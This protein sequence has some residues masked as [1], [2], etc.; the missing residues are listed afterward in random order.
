MAIASRTYADLAD[1]TADI[2]AGLADAEPA[3]KPTGSPARTLAKGA[4]RS[5]ICILLAFALVGVVTLTQSGPVV[6]IAL[7]SA[8]IAILAASAFLGYGVVNAWQE[9]RLHRQL[10]PTSRRDGRKLHGGRPDGTGHDPTLPRDR[11]NRARADLRF[12]RSR[13]GRPHS[14]GRGFRV[15]RAARPVPDLV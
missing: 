15:P 8:L 3:A 7:L 5:G 12:D 2:P 6:G 14:S 10:P 4:R 13:P 9:R 1:L 11:P